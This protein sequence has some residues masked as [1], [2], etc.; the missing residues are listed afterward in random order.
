MLHTLGKLELADTPF[1]RTKLLLFLSYLAFEGAQDRRFVAEL[2][3]SDKN[4]P[5]NSLSAALSQ[6]RKHVPGVIEANPSQ[7][8]TSV[9]CD[10]TLFL[11][12]IE[13]GSYEE[14]LKLYQG[15]FLQGV[16]LPDWSAALEEW[17]YGTREALAE[18]ALEAMLGLAEAKAA[19]GSLA[20]AAQLAEHAYKLP[21]APPMSVETLGR[22]HTLLSTSQSPQ[23]NVVAKEAEELGMTLAPVTVETPVSKIAEATNNLPTLLSSFVGRDAERVELLKQLGK[24]ECRLLTIMGLGG[25]G[26]SRLAIQVAR[27]WLASEPT[28]D[29]AYLVRLEVLTSIHLIPSAIADVLG[30]QLEGQG[31]PLAQVTKAIADKKL[32]LILDNFEQLVEGATMLKALLEPCPNLKLL[33]TSR[34]RLNLSLEQ[35]VGLEGLAYPSRADVSAQEALSHE[36]LQ[37][38]VQRAKH[39]RLD[40]FP[41]LDDVPHLVK[42]AELVQG[43]PLGL[44]LAAAWMKVLSPKE[45]A[46]E[47]T[48]SGDFL[49][50]TARD[51]VDRHSSLKVVFEYSWRLLSHKEQEVMRKLSVFQGGFTREAAS[52]VAEA[53][54]S[55]LARLVDKSLVRVSRQGRYEQH[56]LIYQYCHE[57]LLEYPDELEKTLERHC[58]YHIHFLE[59][60]QTKMQ[61]AG[62]ELQEV[63]TNIGNILAACEWAMKTQKLDSVQKSSNALRVYYNYRGRIQEGLAFF[64]KAIGDAKHYNCVN[65]VTGYLYVN[66]AWLLYIQDQHDEAKKI[67]LLGLDFLKN[68]KVEDWNG[69]RVALNVLGTIAWLEG[70]YSHAKLSWQEILDNSTNFIDTANMFGNLALIEDDL[71]NFDKAEYNYREALRILRNNNQK[72][73]LVRN[74]SNFGEF[75]IERRKLNEAQTIL[76]EGISLAEENGVDNETP[77]L[78]GLIA[79]AKIEL[80]HYAEAEIL[81]KRILTLSKGQGIRSLEALIF[82]DLARV[83][84]ARKNYDGS[85][86]YLLQSL[87]LNAEIQDVRGLAYSLFAVAELWSRYNHLPEAIHLLQ[88]IEHHPDSRASE[89]ERA[90]RLLST[91]AEA[92]F[93]PFTTDKGNIP[94]LA[95]IAQ[96]VIQKLSSTELAPY[97]R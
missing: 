18:Q 22:V 51:A 57:K 42:I 78:L 40:Y 20:E 86:N 24:P 29:S 66:Q 73:A 38:F 4:D 72:V 69:F 96:E 95:Q 8:W 11:K 46:E 12:A 53:T 63:D 3:W 81:C 15:A 91:L 77:F 32:L 52:Q 79:L 92:D 7:V 30:V 25:I 60:R 41:S 31:E 76:D 33:V 10:A 55:L 67:A 85:R 49:A 65:R 21:S 75:L 47:I 59:Q 36:A 74:L 80:G 35:V 56:P 62:P 44:E 1:P 19:Q 45:I 23:A 5:L 68:T 93:Y 61:G 54:L 50:A 94:P 90:K 34:E 14:A 48:K 97:F 64:T 70:D 88:L 82:S 39:A 71:G 28:N 2:F 26:K 17:V 43:S 84:T 16:S 27:D 9:K 13:T 89:K 6:L 83:D 87:H 58:D 37:L